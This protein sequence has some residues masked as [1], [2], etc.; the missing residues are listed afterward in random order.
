MAR[1]PDHKILANVCGRHEA[2]RADEISKAIAKSGDGLVQIRKIEASR[3]I[4]QTLSANPNVS[5]LPGGK[6]GGQFLLNVGR[7]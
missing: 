5:Y 1:L 3:D 2:E 7:T 4:A 6:Q